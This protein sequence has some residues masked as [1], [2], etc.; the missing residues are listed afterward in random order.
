MQLFDT[1]RSC[2]PVA[3]A[4]LVFLLLGLWWRFYEARAMEQC[5]KSYT[6][7]R[8]YRTGGFPFQRKL[9][10]SPELRVWALLA[11]LAAA[12]AF[13]CGRQLCTALQ[14]LYAARVAPFAGLD[15]LL[16]L[17]LCVQGAGAVYSLLTLLFDSPWVSLPGAL[18]F[19][20]AAVRSDGSNALLALSLLCVLL[21]LRAGKPGFPSEF[22]YL[23][24]ILALAL[25]F[26]AQPA[27]LWLVPCFVV[28][29]WYKLLHQLRGRR[30]SVPKLL[31]AVAASLAVW[32]LA[33]LLASMLRPFLGESG[34]TPLLSFSLILSGLGT[35][36]Q[37]ALHSFSFPTVY[38]T[39]DL[40]V[41]APLLGFGVWGCCSAWVLAWKRRDARGYF[42]LA[43]LAAQVLL[44]LV[45]WRCV[46]ILGLTLSTA[47]I[48]RDANLG[49]KRLSTLLPILDGLAWYLF[50][51]IAAWS[52]PLGAALRGWLI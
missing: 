22:L 37:E 39:V 2:W 29:H 1:L 19:A 8:Q 40:L 16:P 46:P 27:M 14:P 48:L 4:S 5:T 33:A 11:A 47:C 32:A 17:C 44:W 15:W 41:D 38:G 3:V 23:A 49:K 28:V 7:V 45:T 30:F 21:Y 18:L 6:W 24:S 35:L 43:V 25:A 36:V 34:K 12:A 20:A 52:L 42:V 9:M 10:G 31:A 13:F 26:S 50:V 51:H